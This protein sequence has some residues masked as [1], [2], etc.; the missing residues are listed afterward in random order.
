MLMMAVVI[1]LMTLIMM[2]IIFTTLIMAV[3]IML[4]TLIMMLIMAHDAENNVDHYHDI[5]DGRA[6]HDH[7]VDDDIEQDHEDLH[8]HQI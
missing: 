6:E 8:F 1:M 7:G 2:S 4:T 5:G 3:M